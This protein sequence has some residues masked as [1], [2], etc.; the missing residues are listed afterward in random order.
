VKTRD[1]GAYTAETDT[2][3]EYLL[4]ARDVEYWR[5]SN[6]PVIIVL[7]HLGRKEAYWKSVD[8]GAGPGTRRLHF[9]KAKDRFD[10]SA[11]D[12]IADLCVSNG[13]WGVWFPTLQGG[14]PGHINM[15]EVILPES[16]F[17]A[18]FAIQDGP[19]GPDQTS[20]RRRSPARPPYDW[21]IRG[22]QFLSFSDPRGGPLEV[23]IDTGSV[24]EIPADE[25]AFPDDE[26]D[27][28]NFIEILRRTLGTQVDGLLSYSRDQKAFYF[29]AMRGIIDSTCHYVSLKQKTSADVVKKYEKDGKLKY[30]RHHTFEARFWRLGDTW[31]MSVTPTFVFTWDGFRPDRFASGRLAGKKQREFNASLLGQFVMWRNLLT[32]LGSS[33]AS[34]ELFVAET[35]REAILRF[36]ALEVMALPLGLLLQIASRVTAARS[37]PDPL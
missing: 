34:A 12:A 21:V 14:E 5:Q 13:G 20:R 10:K 1:E 29:P 32:G 30:V 19:P 28:R 23:V 33:A 16:I 8:A 15:V 6:L 2:A 24:E 9:D 18:A 7:V 25:I 35:E 11:R 3:F 22:G 17:V 37:G 36:K 4:D 26:S 27:E 31:M